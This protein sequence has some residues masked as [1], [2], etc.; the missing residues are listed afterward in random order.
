MNKLLK[1]TKAALL[2]V[3]IVS[4]IGVSSV[5]AQKKWFYGVGTGFTFMNAEGD[6][7]LYFSSTGTI[8]FEVDMGPEDFNDF[9]QSAFGLGGYATDGSWMIA[10]SFG[11][12]KL[13][14][15]V[16]GDLTDED[17]DGDGEYTAEIFFKTFVAEATVGYTAFRS[18]DRNFVVTPYVGGRF[19]K[20]DF[21]TNLTITEGTST[22]EVKEDVDNKWFDVLI[23]SS[24]G[25][26]I[27]PGVTWSL[28][29][30]AGFGGSEG[31]YTFKTGLSWNPSKSWT[32]S[33]NFKY[34]IIE[35]ENEEKGDTDWYLYD[36]DEFGVGISVLVLF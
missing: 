27:S 35:Y 17:G 15:D 29:A 23:G 32:I 18:E 14:D 24:M 28:Q 34:S 36:V 10:G 4:L 9:T 2:T 1:G 22:I 31:T 11:G 16:E 12:L 25:L 7:G 21:G 5:N 30:D 19:M 33:P 8:E 26:V 6:Q 20:H 3:F 13:G